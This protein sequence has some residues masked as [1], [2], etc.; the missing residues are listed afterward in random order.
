MGSEPTKSPSVLMKVF[1]KYVDAS[2]QNL[3][4]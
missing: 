4:E 1:A 3:D 2:H